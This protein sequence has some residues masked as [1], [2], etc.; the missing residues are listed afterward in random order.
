MSNG[1]VALSPFF[2]TSVG[3]TVTPVVVSQT[4]GSIL[5]SL[6]GLSGIWCLLPRYI[7]WPLWQFRDK[8]TSFPSSAI[9][10]MT[11]LFGVVW[12]IWHNSLLYCTKYNTLTLE[13]FHSNLDTF[14]RYQLAGFQD[15]VM[16]WLFSFPYK[17]QQVSV[18][19]RLSIDKLDH[20]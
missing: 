14:L 3:D 16:Y 17:P 8:A 6:E 1:F 15:L 10:I 13:V 11:I 4:A 9:T 18:R 19:F 20:L 7:L 2:I 12:S 5:N